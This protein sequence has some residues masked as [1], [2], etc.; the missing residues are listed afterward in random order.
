VLNNDSLSNF[1][2]KDEVFRRLH[3]KHEQLK[4]M[5]RM[6]NEGEISMDEF[7]LGAMKKEKLSLKD[8]MSDMLQE[9]QH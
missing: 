4:K 5:V 2:E 6:V 8:K 3:D 9:H 7:E 1:L